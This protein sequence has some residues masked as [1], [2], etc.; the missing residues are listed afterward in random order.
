M[1]ETEL[2]FIVFEATPVVTVT[3][4][5]SKPTQNQYYFHIFEIFQ[6]LKSKFLHNINHNRI[7]HI[8]F[9]FIILYFQSGF[10]SVVVPPDILN[11]PDSNNALLEDG[12]TNE[13]GTI[14]LVCVAT[15]VPEPSVMWKREDSKDIILRN[16]GR[17]KQGMK[18]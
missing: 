1:A 16:E 6:K 13:G 8:N 12:I 14:Q 9:I 4:L 18:K 11:Q 5:G 17:D 7:F 10:L 2:K 3:I 15:G